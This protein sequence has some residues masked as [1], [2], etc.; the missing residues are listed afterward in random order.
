M[1]SS[2][3]LILVG[4]ILNLIGAFILAFSLTSYIRAVNNS[5]AALENSL[6]MIANTLNN[7][8]QPAVA[9]QGLDIHRNRGGRKAKGMTIVGLSIM[10]IGFV[11]QILAIIIQT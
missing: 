8:S 7:P 11:I 4:L 5:F 9:F 6:D 3:L 10:I 2:T 1:E